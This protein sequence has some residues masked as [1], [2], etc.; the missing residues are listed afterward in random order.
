MA[1]VPL[2][3]KLQIS[4]CVLCFEKYYEEDGTYDQTTN[5]IIMT[6]IAKRYVLKQDGTYQS[7]KGM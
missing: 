6:D 5:V 2:V 1:M 7:I 3:K 4:Y